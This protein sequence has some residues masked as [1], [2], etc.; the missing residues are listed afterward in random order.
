M[1]D[2]VVILDN[3]RQPYYVDQFGTAAKPGKTVQWKSTSGKF[4]ITIRDSLKF[5]SAKTGTALTNIEKFSIDSAGTNTSQTYTIINSLAT[6]TE[7]EYEV[8]SN[9]LEDQVDAPPKIIIVPAS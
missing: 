1:A 3:G 8:Y 9:T 2:I 5:F 7:K 4:S 6:G